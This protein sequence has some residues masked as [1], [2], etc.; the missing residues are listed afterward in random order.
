MEIS[1]TEAVV[2]L[3][4]MECSRTLDVG[5]CLDVLT[6]P[7][8]FNAIS[9]D[10]VTFDDLKIDVINQL[11]CQV[12]VDGVTIGVAQFKPMFA[13]CWDA[14]IHVLPEFRK[15]YA[16]QAGQM[17]WDWISGKLP[18]ALIYTTVPVFCSNVREFLIS[19]KFEETG[20]L[21]GAWLKNGKQN[22]MYILTR[23]TK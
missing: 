15:F 23:R 2:N 1:M 22:D 3:H 18:K 13:R 4:R 12:S 11:W 9:E 7:E 20:Y 16:Q 14:H 5:V 17:I 8:I 6:N 19:F 10:D 21:D